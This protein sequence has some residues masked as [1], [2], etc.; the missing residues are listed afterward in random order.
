M[1]V[2]DCIY[3]LVCVCVYVCVCTFL[4]VV[5]VHVIYA[6]CVLHILLYCEMED[7]ST[8]L[9]KMYAH[10]TLCLFSTPER[11]S[12]VKQHTTRYLLI[13]THTQIKCITIQ[14]RY[15]GETNL[16][17]KKQQSN[18]FSWFQAPEFIDCDQEKLW[19]LMIWIDMNILI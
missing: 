5:H 7:L 10:F 13:E 19:S 12:Y 11:H 6:Q 16:D 3:K 8:C 14:L 2:Y 15:R 9:E 1:S 17:S 18:V 4:I